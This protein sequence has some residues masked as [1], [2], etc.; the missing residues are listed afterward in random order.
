MD[1]IG[2]R[3]GHM[4]RFMYP[5]PPLNPDFHAM[6]QPSHP[7]A[8]AAQ[9]VSGR[10]GLLDC[11]RYLA[12]RL[13]KKELAEALEAMREPDGEEQRGE[14]FGRVL[15]TVRQAGLRPL[16][17]QLPVERLSDLAERLP[18][19]VEFK[20]GHYRILSG[21]SVSQGQAELFLPGADA[22]M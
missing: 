2:A 16:V 7:L 4:A 13:E 20:G 8:P 15:E 5:L 11:C 6:D 22:G 1:Y 21:L 3:P 9:P 12:Q 19:V 14:F 10:S 17:A 18:V